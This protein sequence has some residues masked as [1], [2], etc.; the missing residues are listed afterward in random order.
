MHHGPEESPL[1]YNIR[2]KNMHNK[3][4]VIQVGNV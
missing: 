1:K 4:N 3:Y 2:N